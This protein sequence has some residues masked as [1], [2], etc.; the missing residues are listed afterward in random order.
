MPVAP[1]QLDPESI[2]AYC[3]TQLEPVQG[4]MGKHGALG[5][6]SINRH[7]GTANIDVFLGSFQRFRA[8]FPDNLGACQASEGCEKVT[9][10]DVSV[11]VTLTKD[12][13]GDGKI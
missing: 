8:Q 12:K 10:V 4:N 13:D 2:F 11:A 9:A 7:A 6:V 5:L 3:A 1:A